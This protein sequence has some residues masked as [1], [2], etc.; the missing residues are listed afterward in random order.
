MAAAALCCGDAERENW[1]KLIRRTINT[2][3][4]EKITSKKLQ[5]TQE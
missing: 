3:H 2:G 1:L 5:K 4:S